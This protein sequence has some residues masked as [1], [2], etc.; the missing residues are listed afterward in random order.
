MGGYGVKWKERGGGV[1]RM[2]SVAAE[3]DED[4]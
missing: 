3:S 1:G 4:P 2:K